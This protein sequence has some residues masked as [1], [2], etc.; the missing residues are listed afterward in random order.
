MA[1]TRD[2]SPEAA[3]VLGPA[4]VHHEM[5]PAAL[6]VP[7]DETTP[8]GMDPGRSPMRQ[9][10][11]LP[12]SDERR[13]IAELENLIQQLRSDMQAFQMDLNNA[14]FKSYDNSIDN[15]DIKPM[16]GKDMKAPPDYDGSRKN[17][18]SWHESFISM[19]TCKTPKWQIIL[20]YCI[21]PKTNNAWT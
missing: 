17:C 16:N 3:T 11:L 6:P 7:E 5:T 14:R 13:R 19:L 9:P 8:P 12:A 15:L 20:D 2:L 18:A 10:L 4:T 21:I 1:T